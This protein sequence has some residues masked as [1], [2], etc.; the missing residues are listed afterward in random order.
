M[1][2]AL[3]LCLAVG[4]S[5]SAQ[6][7]HFP[8]ANRTLLEAG[9]EEKFFV[10]TVG[11]PWTSGSFGCV[12]TEG[13]QMHEGLD[14]RCLQRD[15]TGEPKDPVLATADGTIAYINARPSL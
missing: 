10:G 1:K 12:R 13:W 11:K 8:T 2:G 3:L 7:F 14:I 4:L 5:A 9:Q 15:K 6:P